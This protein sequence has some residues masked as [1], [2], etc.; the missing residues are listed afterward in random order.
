MNLD[1]KIRSTVCDAQSMTSANSH[2]SGTTDFNAEAKKC[3]DRNSAS[4]KRWGKEYAKIADSRKLAKKK[5]KVTFSFTSANVVEEDLKFARF[6]TA[7]RVKDYA[8]SKVAFSVAY[9][10]AFPEELFGQPD[11]TEYAN[12]RSR[13]QVALNRCLMLKVPPMYPVE[14]FLA[15]Y[16][17][18]S[19][20]EFADA[21]LYGANA[22][23]N[24]RTA[25]NV[26]YQERKEDVLKLPGPQPPPRYTGANEEKEDDDDDQFD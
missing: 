17:A 9:E 14:H 25:A 4:V 18:M 23:A 12:I 5:K 10:L 24:M 8:T 20:K 22:P 21:V 7:L 1:S 6:F 16:R 19:V 11:P 26:V 2:V 15:M 3:I 13:A